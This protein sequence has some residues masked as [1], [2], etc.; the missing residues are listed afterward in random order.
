MKTTNI[1]SPIS[2][3]LIKRFHFTLKLHRNRKDQILYKAFL[4]S[5]Y[6]EFLNLQIYL[7][8][9]THHKPVFQMHSIK[10]LIYGKEWYLY[11][12]HAF[13]SNTSALHKQH[14]QHIW[15]FPS[16]FFNHS[17]FLLD[18]L[19]HSNRSQSHILIIRDFQFL[20]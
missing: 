12:I 18:I 11:H 17:I 10:Y 4:D 9:I 19:N 15:I 6:K 3:K 7:Q 16:H 8:P 14:H 13:C 20:S 1:F 2:R 5:H